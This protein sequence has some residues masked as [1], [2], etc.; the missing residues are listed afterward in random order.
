MKKHAIALLTLLCALRAPAQL[1]SA[2]SGTVQ[3][4]ENFPSRYVAARNQFL[5]PLYLSP[6]NGPRAAPDAP[7]SFAFSGVQSQQQP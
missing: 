1:P 5:Y 4:F 6:P 2:G 7:G 3:R